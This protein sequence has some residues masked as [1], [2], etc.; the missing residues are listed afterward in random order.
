[1]KQILNWK[2]KETE[3]DMEESNPMFEKPRN[4]LEL[5]VNNENEYKNSCLIEENP[6]YIHKVL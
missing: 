6:Y 1:M 4:K 2:M 5:Y 3:D